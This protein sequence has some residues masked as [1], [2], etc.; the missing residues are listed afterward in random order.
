M[1]FNVQLY[2]DSKYINNKSKDRYS[3]RSKTLVRFQKL[4][5]CYI[6]GCNKIN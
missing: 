6:F 3:S 4:Y 5:M 2:F 1:L